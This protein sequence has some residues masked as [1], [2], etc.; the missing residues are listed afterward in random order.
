VLEPLT[1]LRS[2]QNK[3]SALSSGLP[4]RTANSSDATTDL[5]AVPT[6]Q[7]QRQDGGV[8]SRATPSLMPQSGSDRDSK[9]PSP[10]GST[11][12]DEWSSI[13]ELFGQMT[14]ESRVETE[15]R[16]PIQAERGYPDLNL[17]PEA[18]VPDATIQRDQ[19]PNPPAVITP[20][21]AVA[22]QNEHLPS[23]Q[24]PQPKAS[25]EQLEQ[26]ALE[27][28]RLVRQRLALEQERAGK[29]YSGRLL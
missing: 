23:S 22:S 11:T 8:S 5:F 13:A 17:Y 1:Q 25:P 28:Y 20:A 7:A 15:E 16:S 29:P 2:L 27:I 10:N 21:T 9:S 24:Q 4:D 18:S 6:L 19:T 3:P 14:G 12:P 26:L